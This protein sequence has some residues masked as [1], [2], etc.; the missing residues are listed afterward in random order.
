MSDDVPAQDFI[1]LSDPDVS[2]AEL[3]AADRV[4][5]APRL[6]AGPIVE[7]FESAFAE[8]VGRRYAVAVASGG[9]GMLLAL[10]AAGIGAGDEVITAPLAWHQT[11]HAIRHVGARPVF[12]DIDYWTCSIAPDKAATRVGPGTRALIAGN[13]N[14]HPAAWAELQELAERRGLMLLEDSTEAIGSRYQGR[15][16][17][18]FGAL[19]VFDFSHPGV[20]CCGEGGIVVTDDPELDSRLR[21]L[22]NPRQGERQ[23]VGPASSTAAGVPPL[24]ACLSDIAAAIGLAQLDRI[25][26]LLARRKTIEMLYERHIQSFEGIKPPY[27]SPAVTEVHWFL[28]LVHLGTRFTRSARDAI[29]DDL[30]TENIEAAAMFRPLHAENAYRDLGYRKGELFVAEK[31]ADRAIA[32]P[33]HAHLSDEQVAFIVQTAKDAS[34]NVGAGSAIYL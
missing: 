34:I 3:G 21:R 32:L 31:I 16:V 17:G 23:S 6:S 33:F 26:E 10:R 18:S 11:A 13:V 2:T 15:A 7:A 28:Y 25:D 22:R 20:L 27:V 29:I 12:A 30:A 4:L 5:C 24:A 1:P 8:Y 19:S 14:G 9:I